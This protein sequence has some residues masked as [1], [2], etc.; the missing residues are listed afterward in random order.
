VRILHIDKFL[1]GRGYGGGVESCIDAMARAQ[2]AAGHDVAEFGTAR[3]DDAP[4]MPRFFDFSASPSPLNLPRM[5][6]NTQAA[7]KLE[8]FLRPRKFDVAHIHSLY[9]HLTP[10]ILPVLARR[11]IGIVMQMHDYRMACPSKHFLRP[12]DG[13]HCMRCQPN[14]YFHAADKG[15][16]GPAGAGPTIESYIARMTRSYFR[17]VDF[18]VCPTRFMRKIMQE[19]GTPRSKLIVL[20]NMVSPLAKPARKKENPR[21]V[22]FAGRMSPEKAPEM[23]LDLAERIDDIEVVLAGDGPMLDEL[24]R[25]ASDRKLDNVTFTGHI[26]AD[27]VGA[28]MHASAA[29]I[30]TSRWLENSTMTMLEAMLAG[31]CVIVPDRGPLREWIDDGRTGRLFKPDDADLLVSV[32]QQVLSNAAA[33][34]KMGAAGKELTTRRHDPKLISGRLEILYK[35]AISRS[36]LRW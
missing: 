34:R 30:V 20:R 32:T 35:E 27:D 5:I 25:S 33:R 29:V 13:V 31:R 18:F 3:A 1:P 11:G 6:H 28:W 4:E 19:I 2:R 24:R 23:M 15:C 9:H 17:W 8:E 12:R 14:K 36:A 16:A 26:S 7:S 21:R 10:S 22:L